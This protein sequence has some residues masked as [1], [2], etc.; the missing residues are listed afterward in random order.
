MTSSHLSL[1]FRDLTDVP[2]AD[3]QR[4]APVRFEEIMKILYFFLVCLFV[5]SR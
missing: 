5:S 2:L 1:A 3:A 4:L